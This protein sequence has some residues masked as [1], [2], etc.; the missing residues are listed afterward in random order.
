MGYVRKAL[1]LVWDDDED[2][3]FH[4]LEVS[5]RRLPIG[6]LLGFAHL[7]ELR[8][9]G[10]EDFSSE[11]MDQIKHLFATIGDAL[12]AWNLELEDGTPVPADAEGLFSQDLEFGMEIFSQWIAAITR[13]K[14]DL[15]KDS[16]SGETSLEESI[17]MDVLS[18]S[19]VSS[20]MPS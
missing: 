6:T 18:P 1:K 19:P 11:E 15:G 5:I 17:P 2:S 8:D 13:V 10:T 9:M 4:G 16:P 7:L 3:D 12:V 20:S 14:P